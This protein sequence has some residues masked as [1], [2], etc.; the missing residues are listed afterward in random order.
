MDHTDFIASNIDLIQEEL[1]VAAQ[2]QPVQ[3]DILIVV[4]DQ[5]PFLRACVESIYRHTADFNLFIWDN[6]SNPAMIRYLDTL[7]GVYVHREERNLGFIQPN[8]RL[9][10]LGTSPYIILLNSDTVV[11]Q[12]W[13]ETMIAWLQTHPSVR[14]VGYMGGVLD[15]EMRGSQV[16]FGEAP[17]Y[18]CG[19]CMCLSRSTFNECGLFD[20]GNLECAY[21]ED[22]DFSLRL[23]ERGHQ[24]FAL[25]SGLVFHAGN[26]TVKQVI[27]EQGVKELSRTFEANH[28]YLQTRW[29]EFVDKRH[30]TRSK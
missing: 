29:R 6:G 5:L 20:E 22:A 12:G 17:D 14:E 1:T 3:K 23:L 26:A 24:I 30:A 25:R 2:Y 18:I 19:W 10:A 4:H 15:E 28:N 21:G 16:D 11:H 7:R 13:D 8:N 27:T 9:A